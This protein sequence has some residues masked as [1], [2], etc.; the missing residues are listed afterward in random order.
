MS[1][2]VWASGLA[3][4]PY[5][6]RWSRLVAREFLAWL[7]APPGGRWIDVGCGTGALS[8]TVLDSAGPFDLTAL[9]RS[10]GYT[11]FAR[12]QVRDDR[13]CFLVGDATR[14]PLAPGLYDVAVSGLVLNFVP[15]PAQ[16]VAEMV[17][18]VRP[19]GL[20]AVYVWDYAGGMEFQRHFWD[21]AAALDPPA[22][23]VDTGQRFPLCRPEPLADLWRAAGLE[24]VETRAIDVPT[25]FRDF[26]DYWMPFLGGQ[27]TVPGYVMALSAERRAALRDHLH[28]RLPVAAGGSISLTARA[29]A[30]RG[31]RAR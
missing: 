15:R 30:V 22:R 21:A 9:D 5:M 26:D 16:M 23:G 24:A 17:R 20:V 1:T 29:W 8:G 25:R 12:Q 6:G 14:L 11:Q 2:E 7:D 10:A 4:E 3:Y 18:V 31:Q 28:T 27:G 13:A 19:H